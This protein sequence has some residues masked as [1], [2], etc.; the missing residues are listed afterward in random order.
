MNTERWEC[1]ADHQEDLTER[2][3]AARAAKPPW[4]FRSVRDLL[5]RGESQTIVVK[6]SE[7]HENVIE[8]GRGS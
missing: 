2:V 1:W 3:Q 8:L 5:G 7:G 6:C 4:V